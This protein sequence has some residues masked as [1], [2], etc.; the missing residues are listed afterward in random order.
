[1]IDSKNVSKFIIEAQNGDESSFNILYDLTNAIIY[2]S[3]Y[4]IIRNEDT[5][6]D[7]V[8]DTFL[9]VLQGKLKYEDN[10]LSYLITIAKNLAINFYNKS[11][12][13]ILIDFEEEENIY[14]KES[15]K[16]DDYAYIKEL[17][18]SNLSPYQLSLI[19]MHIEEGLTHKEIAKRLNKPIGTITWQY[20]EALKSLRVLI[21]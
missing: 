6:L 16:D 1:M 20:N 5:S 14:R 7:L 21:K 12:K 8:Q 4:K 15:N 9:K 17:M 10:G 2:D 19:N 11:K 13:E 3:I 18:Q